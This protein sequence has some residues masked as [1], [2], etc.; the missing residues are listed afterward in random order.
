MQNY[1]PFLGAVQLST[2]GWVYRTVT[3]LSSFFRNILARKMDPPKLT[4][5]EAAKLLCVGHVMEVFT[6]V[7][8]FFFLVVEEKRR[9]G[10]NV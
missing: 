3:V 7:A 4:L 5:I 8:F 9:K 2:E 10:G 6:I 1:R